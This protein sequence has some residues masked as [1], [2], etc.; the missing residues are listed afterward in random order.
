MKE[1]ISA[2]QFIKEAFQFR[3]KRI[4]SGR[5]ENDRYPMSSFEKIKLIVLTLV[6][7]RKTEEL[8]QMYS[9]YNYGVYL[10]N[11]V[12]PKIDNPDE[13]H[14]RDG[15]VC[16]EEHPIQAMGWKEHDE[17][18]EKGVQS[19]LNEDYII[20][21]FETEAER[22]GIDLEWAFFE[23]VPNNNESNF[24]SLSTGTN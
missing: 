1:Q 24:V 22:R 16:L 23:N 13:F 9:S 17:L 12:F 6:S 2:T 20:I 8:I 11:S 5:F 10:L 15:V 4:D 21:G 19:G 14:S 7:K 3:F 18:I